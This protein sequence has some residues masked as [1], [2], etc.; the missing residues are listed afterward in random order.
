MRGT[1][2]HDRFSGGEEIAHAIT[3]GLGSLCSVAGLVVLIWRASSGGDARL[4]VG[5]TV[6]GTAMLVLYTASTLY[7]ALTAARAKFVFKLLDHGAIY[8]LI[9]GS[10]TPFALIVLGGGWGWT[11]FGLSWGLATLGI[12]YEV[13]WRRPW[14]WLSL[15]FY[16][17]LGWLAVIAVKPL[18]AVLPTQALLLMGC[19]GVAYSGGAVFY[20]WRG[21]PYHH[22]VW[23]LFVLAGTALHYFCVLRFVIPAG[24]P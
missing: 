9:A 17:A 22:A 24:M 6:F 12:L 21:F 4:V 15:V 16:L 3:H 18:M 5:V 8:L 7:H 1:F 11:L 19:G 14:K 2:A 20:A 10:Y 13:V 23:H